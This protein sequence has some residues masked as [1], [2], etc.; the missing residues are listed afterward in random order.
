MVAPGRLDRSATGT[1]LSAR[2]AVLHARGLMRVGDAMTHA[3]VLG[4]DLRRADRLGDARRRARGD[5]AGDPRQRLDHRRHA[6]LRRSGRSVSRGLRAAGYVGRQRARRSGVAC[7]LASTGPGR[8]RALE[9]GDGQL[10]G[11]SRTRGRRTRRRTSS[12]STRQCPSSTGARGRPGIATRPRRSRS[13]AA[14]GARR[15]SQRRGLRR[16]LPRTWPRP[17]S[18]APRCPASRRPRSIGAPCSTASRSIVVASRSASSIGQPASLSRDAL[19]LDGRDQPDG[20]R[21]EPRSRPKR[22][23]ARPASPRPSS[24]ASAAADAGRRRSSA[25]ARRATTARAAPPASTPPVVPPA[26]SPPSA[27]PPRSRPRAHD[28]GAPT[29][30]RRR[31]TS[32]S[33]GGVRSVARSS[34]CPTWVDRRSRARS[35]V[36]APAETT[37]AL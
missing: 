8:G 19:E 11:R 27:A 9:G 28:P 36:A 5:R 17:P 18:P 29:C 10:D 26:S 35:A 20:L 3:S 33:R 31:C 12:P 24:A 14:P 7:E 32:A 13:G 21:Q 30:A 4:S 1:G 25:R 37:L 22:P 2:L 23:R 34:S 15:R 6:A 16:A